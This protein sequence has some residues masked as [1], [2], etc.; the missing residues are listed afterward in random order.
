MEAKEVLVI[1]AGIAGCATALALAKRGISV[2]IATSSADQRVYHGSFI[3]DE[4]LQDDLPKLPELLH[5][6]L[7]SPRAVEQ[8]HKLAKKSVH[9][10]VSE[11][12]T[13]DRHGNV[14]IHLCLQEQLRTLSNVEWL[15]HHVLLD[16]ITL[17]RDSKKIADQHKKPCCLG[18]WIYNQQLKQLEPILAKEVV[19]ATGGAASLYAYSTHPAYTRGEGLGI[20][21]RASVRL[22]QMNKIEFCPLSLF[23]ENSPAF[24]LPLEL[25]TEGGRFLLAKNGA[26]WTPPGKEALEKEIFD[27]LVRSQRRHLWLDLTFGAIASIKEKFPAVDSYCLTR[28]FNLAKEL[29]PVVPAACYTS[30]GIAV[31]GAAQSSMQRL[32]AV[33]EMASTGLVYNCKN[34]ALR[35]LE[36]LTWAAACA[37]EIAKQIG[38]LVYYFPEIEERNQLPEM[39]DSSYEEE[40]M[41]MRQILWYY[42]GIQTSPKRQQRALTLLHSLKESQNKTASSIAEIQFRNSL[43]TAI[44]IAS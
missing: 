26:H 12:Y 35:V 23:E 44:L 16:L 9:E 4:F 37:E 43:R 32:R 6:S 42:A 1:G 30:G 33:G 19:L 21:A 34:E 5:A 8:L 40:W 18:A 28:G 20:A 3:Q 13:V 36:S 11:N 27:E 29:L 15:E 24:P 14:D 39:G 25:L 38:K 22:I 31:D 17:E 2:A 10:L 7:S 41:L